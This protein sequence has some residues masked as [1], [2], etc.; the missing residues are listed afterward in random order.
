M[1]QNTPFHRNVEDS[2][3]QLFSYFDSIINLIFSP[4]PKAGNLRYILIQIIFIFTWISCA[5]SFNQPGEINYQ[6]LDFLYT[7]PYPIFGTVK[8]IIELFLAWD[9]LLVMFTIYIGYSIALQ[10]SSIYLADIFEIK[11]LSISEK[12]INQSAFS[13]PNYY[14]IHVE[15]AQ[16]RQEDQKSPIYRIGG[17]GNVI[18]NLENAVVF[19]KI[20][21]TPRIAGPTTEK[22]IE[23]ESFERIRKIIDLRDQ[24]ASLDISAR[25]LD[26]ISIDI[27][28]IRIIFSVLRNTSSA[29]LSK[30][31]PFSDDAIHWLVYQQESGPWTT[32]LVELVRAE[33]T[34]YINQHLLSELL[35]AI[36]TPEV[37][38]QIQN[39]NK[40]AKKIRK[41]WAHTR[42]YKVNRYFFGK[43]K[44]GAPDYRPI[45]FK[46]KHNKIQRASKLFI[47][48]G[49]II[50]D[51]VPRTA[52]SKLFYENISSSFQS[53]AQKN[54]M[55][56]EWIN[57]GTWH[58]TST[59]IP[60]QHIQA[61]KISSENTL[62]LNPKVLNGIFYQNRNHYLA[63]NIQVLPIISF[64]QKR[65]N[66]ISN[67]E[68]MND[69]INEYG[70][71]LSSARDLY[72]NNKGRV[73]LQI[74]K[75]LK[76]IKKY[77][78]NKLK[79]QALFIGE[80][81]NNVDEEKE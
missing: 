24:T 3:F 1:N 67:Q 39:Q 36:G 72:I 41:N 15:D 10:L 80:K 77:Q 81:D 19:E 30:P 42:R 64:I 37:N 40:I 49:L 31:Y 48:K 57:V 29:T 47:N 65:E 74:E 13:S 46:K 73:P 22:S 45:Y 28:D 5:F 32:S 6:W 68:I 61:W 75:S 50:P 60:E 56:L 20:D 25:T 62:K 35:A 69:L 34:N 78:I 4:N 9:V 71:K 8:G 11:D 27:K 52:L 17:P 59:I 55:R 44:K 43:L 63:Q 53:K 7:I 16:V 18:I 79:N 14:Q 23:L 2:S 51:F 70:S 33:L 76:H 12:Y 21:G 38:I 26:G 66:G 54:G 58:S